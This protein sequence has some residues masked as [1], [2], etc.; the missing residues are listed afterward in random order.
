MKNLFLTFACVILAGMLY[1]NHWTPIGGT[2]YNMTMSGIIIIDGVEQ[3][4]TTLEVGAF[5]GDECRGSML[6][7]FF[8]PSQQ[9]V[10]SLTVVSNQL[11]GEEITFRLYDHNAQQ[12]LNLV[13]ANNTTFVSNAIIGTLGDWYEFSFVSPQPGGNHWTPIGGTQYNM[14]MSGIIL[15][16]GVEQMGTNLEVGAF[17]GDECRGSMLPE[18]FPPTNQFVVAL[19]VASNQLSGEEIVFRLYDHNTQQELDLESVNNTIFENNAMIGAPGNWYEF[20]FISSIHP[21]TFTLPIAGY[22]NSAGGYYLIAPPIDDVDPTSVAGMTE[23]DFDLYYF[24][25]SQLQEEWR[26]YEAEPFNLES[27]KGYLYAH[28][29]DVTLTFTGTPYSGNGQVTLS[30]T[31][32]V[33]LSG[34]NLVG[35]PFALT[36]TIDRECYVMNAAGTEI[37]AGN[38]RT[39]NPMQGVFVIAAEEGETLTFIPENSTDEGS[40]IVVEVLQGNGVSKDAAPIDR[41]IV[42]FGDNNTLPK[43]MLNPENTK[44]YIP[45]EDADYAVTGHNVENATPVSFKASHNGTYTL[46]FDIVNLDL[47]YLHLID[48]KTG[49]DI[50][51]LDQKHTSTY[52]FEALTTDYAERFKLVYATANG[53][54]EGDN[55]F[56]YYANGEI[57]LF[58]VEEGA[59]LQVV[60][61]KGRMVVSHNGRIQCVPTDG[62]SP[63][64]Y[65]LRLINGDETRVQKIVV[66]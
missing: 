27:G 16:D 38:T 59:S 44:L 15:I 36:A 17:C 6:P 12:E 43:L 21:Q 63:G 28:K 50:D 46:S 57:R 14:T 20:S 41:A 60:D 2:Q 55:P 53:V 10:V 25:Q 42:R 26:N 23:G 51:L 65:L 13:S 35:N 56:A 62:M 40:R 5:C 8:P 18:F 33:P 61:T 7:E 30:K 1:A 19:T 52:T 49:D 58:E 48:N 39:V 34:W 32:G 47:E 29:T 4:G 37:I 3:T 9:F 45:A 54:D 64:V 31:N 24:D 11:S 22:G 66:K